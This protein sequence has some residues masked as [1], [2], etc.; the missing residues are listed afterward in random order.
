MFLSVL[1]RPSVWKVI[2]RAIGKD[3]DNNLEGEGKLLRGNVINE[4][5]HNSEPEIVNFFKL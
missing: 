3:I 4:S 1:M 2:F 5:F